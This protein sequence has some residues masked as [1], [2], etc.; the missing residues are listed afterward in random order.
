MKIKDIVEDRSIEEEPASRALCTS[1]KPDSAL[2]V[3]WHL[4]SHRVIVL[5][6]EEKAIR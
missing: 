3:N 2:G 6:T 5:V 1:G 4:V